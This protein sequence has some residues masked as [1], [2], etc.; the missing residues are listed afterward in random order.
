MSTKS[1]PPRPASK[2]QALRHRQALAAQ[3]ASPKVLP[4]ELAKIV[5][6]FDIARYG[7]TTQPV[8]PF[9][10]EA[11]R[12]SNV[13]GVESVRKHCR[14]ITALAVFTDAQGLPLTIETALTTDNIDDYIRR[15]MTGESDNRLERRRRLLW[16]ASAANPGPNTPARLSP[17]SYDAVKPPYTPMERAAIM[18][19][20]RTQPNPRA[21]EQLAAIVALGFGAGGD[22]VDLRDLRIRDITGDDQT[23]AVVAFHGPRPRIVPVRR[24]AEDLLLGA[25]HGRSAE[26]L[27]IGRKQGRRN[28]AAR[29][30]EDAALYKIPH[31]EPGRMRA[32]WLADLMTDPIPIAVILQ[33][34]G[35]KSART[36]VD[37]LPHLGPWCELKGLPAVSLDVLRGGAR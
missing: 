31:I 18:R 33:A 34:A 28:T 9:L 14:H 13:T 3:A 36:L 5:A 20:A 24:V 8:R 27:V 4:R 32:T 21:G 7:T 16:V 12:R 37:V 35:L 17:I 26:E 25:V 30:V 11:I 15:G 2:A 10:A 6:D 23:G 29:V 22:S 19:A 1:T